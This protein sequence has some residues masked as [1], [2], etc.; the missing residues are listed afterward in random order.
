MD[1]LTTGWRDEVFKGMNLVNV[2]RELIARG[3]LQP[4][5]KGKAA[6]VVALPGLGSTRAY[7]VNNAALFAEEP[8]A[9]AV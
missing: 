6:Q 7:V 4:D 1:V 5:S 2:N 8:M 3:I 9:E